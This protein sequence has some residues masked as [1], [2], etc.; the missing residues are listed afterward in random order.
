MAESSRRPGLVG[1]VIVPLVVGFL[2]GPLVSAGLALALGWSAG[3]S[4]EVIVRLG[5]DGKEVSRVEKTSEPPPDLWLDDLIRNSIS[6]SYCLCPVFTA[7]GFSV[8]V[9]RWSVW[10]REQR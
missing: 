7:L 2:A 4:Q 6:L 3:T 5:P 1:A 9:I 10:A 8:G